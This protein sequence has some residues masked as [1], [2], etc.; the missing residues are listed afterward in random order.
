[1][2]YTPEQDGRSERYIKSV[3]TKS[4]YTFAEKKILYDEWPY[5]VQLAVHILN[6]SPTRSNPQ[7]KTPYELFYGRQLEVSHLRT[8]VH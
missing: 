1:M 4:R 7:Y 8:P 5:V 3:L 6:R 2:P